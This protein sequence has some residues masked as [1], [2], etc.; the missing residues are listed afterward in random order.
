VRC[1]LEMVEAARALPSQ[2]DVRV[3]V[4]VGPVVAGVVGRRQYL[5]DLWGDTV[6]TAARVESH[7]MAGAVNVSDTAWGQ[8]SAACDG[9]SLGLV[10]VK[11]KGHK[12]LFRVRALRVPA[13]G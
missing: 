12:E 1:G 8:V 6:N 2:W 7:G 5:F 3:G 4:H 10:M 11:G 9:D 13:A